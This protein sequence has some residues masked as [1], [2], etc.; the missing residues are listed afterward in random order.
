MMAI[1]SVAAVTIIAAPAAQAASYYYAY[2]ISSSEWQYRHSGQRP[3]IDGGEAWT[4]YLNAEGAT[5]TVIIET[6]YPA[7]GYTTVGYARAGKH[8]YMGHVAVSNARQKCVWDWGY[9]GGNV[10]SLDL[11]CFASY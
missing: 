11:T 6:Y 10:G 8:V 5:S 4:E 9:A 3:V 2:H 1:S 7:P